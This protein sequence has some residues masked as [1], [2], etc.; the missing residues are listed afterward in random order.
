MAQAAFHRDLAAQRLDQPPHQRQAEARALFRE[1]I[2]AVEDGAQPLGLDA[3][4]GVA[5]RE[6]HEVLDLLGGQQDL[7]V[8][9]RVA[10][11]IRKQVVEDRTQGAPVGLHHRQ[12]GVGVDLDAD[13]LFGGLIAIA[14]AGFAQS[15]Q[16]AQ[17]LEL[18][19]ALAGVEFGH[20]DQVAHQVVELLGLVAG[21]GHKLGLQG[22]QLAAKALAERVEAAPQLQQRIA[23]LAAGDGDELRLEAVGILQAGH[24]F[25]R[26]HGAQQAAFGVAHGRGAQAIAALLLAD[27]HGQHRGFVFGGHGLLHGD[28]VANGAQNLVA[29]RRV[30][31]RHAVAGGLAQ[32]LRGGLVHL[33]HVSLAVGDDDGLKDGLQH[34]VGELKL[35]LAAAGL[36]VAQFAQP[37][38]D[39]AQLAGEHAEVVAAA[40]LH[41]MLQIALRDA[42]RIAGQRAD[43]AQHEVDGCDLDQQRGQNKGVS[44]GWT[45]PPPPGRDG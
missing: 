17:P 38:R 31:Q 24:V 11:R 32:Q 4:A 41:A 25:E 16:R 2:E 9:R 22:Q 13:V 35:H 36:G 18:E 8:L 23:Q 43:G 27:A 30:G 6:L 19:L 7:A 33:E 29:A 15:L 28:R 34:G 3:A 20:F 37:D 12:I 39:A 5:H 44:R 40:P 26:G 42:M 45:A 1:G 10:N 14:V 21:R